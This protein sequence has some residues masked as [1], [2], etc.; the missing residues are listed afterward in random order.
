M[1]N[2]IQAVATGLFNAPGPTNIDLDG[3][4]TT[5]HVS[6]TLW[7]GDDP[8]Q[9]VMNAEGQF[10]Q[11]TN[12]QD[13]QPQDDEGHGCAN[14]GRRGRDFVANMIA[15]PTFRQ[16]RRSRHRRWRQPCCWGDNGPCT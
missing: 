14:D 8:S 16:I 11:V 7:L 2:A 13:G 4:E 6:G 15:H 5:F 1:N 12:L 9:S 3:L 10:H